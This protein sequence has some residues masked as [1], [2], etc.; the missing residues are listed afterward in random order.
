MQIIQVSSVLHLLLM[1]LGVAH[2]VFSFLLYL[3][4]SYGLPMAMPGRVWQK[5]KKNKVLVDQAAGAAGSA[6]GGFFAKMSWII[7]ILL[8]SS[9]SGWSMRGQEALSG[10]APF[11][12]R[13]AGRAG[14][15]RATNAFGSF[16]C[17]SR[18][19]ALYGEAELR[20]RHEPSPFLTLV[21]SMRETFVREPWRS[22]AG[23]GARY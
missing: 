12:P 22:L 13:L 18:R 14:P 23:E 17:F 5:G 2:T 11:Q 4:F 19:S 16:F 1:L 21:C 9:S 8:A 10:P 15:R 3:F 6:S 20:C 7:W